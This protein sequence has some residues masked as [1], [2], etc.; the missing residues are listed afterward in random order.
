MYTVNIHYSIVCDSCWKR[1]RSKV[2]PRWNKPE[3]SKWN[4]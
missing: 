2:Y 4:Y 3:K 1:Q